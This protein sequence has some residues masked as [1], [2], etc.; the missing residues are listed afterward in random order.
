MTRLMIEPAALCFAWTELEVELTPLSFAT[1]S[2]VFGLAPLQAESS[3][4]ESAL[5]QLGEP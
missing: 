2:V 5:L 4:A 1:Q 3:E